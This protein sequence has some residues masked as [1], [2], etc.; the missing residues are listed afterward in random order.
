M[1]KNKQQQTSGGERFTNDEWFSA[2]ESVSDERMCELNRVAIEHRKRCE[3]LLL[4]I[5]QALR[6]TRGAITWAELTSQINGVGTPI[7]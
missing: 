3:T 6:R 2:W 5:R 1:K 7:I 4:D